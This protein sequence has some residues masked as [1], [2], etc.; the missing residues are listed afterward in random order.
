MT[1]EMINERYQQG[2]RDAVKCLA[3]GAEGKTC[4]DMSVAEYKSYVYGWNAGLKENDK[5]EK[6]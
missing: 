6:G 3:N 2:Y 1:D 5:S 4:W